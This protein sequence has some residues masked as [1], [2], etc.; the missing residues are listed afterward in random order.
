[1][2]EVEAMNAVVPPLH[3][4]A[5]NLMGAMTSSDPVADETGIERSHLNNGLNYRLNK[6]KFDLK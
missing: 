4:C 6:V 5:S 3:H 2:N 1:M